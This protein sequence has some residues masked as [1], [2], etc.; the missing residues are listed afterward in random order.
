MSKC[1][2]FGACE[3]NNYNYIRINKN[4]NDII[5]CADGGIKHTLKLGII[6]D[7]LIGDMDSTNKMQAITIIKYN[8]I[9]NDTDMLLAVKKAIEL[10]YKEINIYGGIG[11]RLDHT[12]ANFQILAY[13][14]DNDCNGYLYDEKTVVTMTKDKFVFDNFEYKYISIFSYGEKIDKVTIK[15]LKYEI[16]DLNLFNTFPIGISNEHINKKGSVEINQGK[17]LI[18]MC[19]E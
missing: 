16:C 13:I 8:P 18:I 12:Y 15:G 7:I 5:I 6:P 14:I 10:G 17:L 9:K 19:N 11:G 2:I 3:I 1:Y 4:E